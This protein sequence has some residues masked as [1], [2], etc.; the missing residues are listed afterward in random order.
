[1][2]TSSTRSG[3]SSLAPAGRVFAMQSEQEDAVYNVASGTETSLL[4]LWEAIQ[5]VT[6][7]HTTLHVAERLSFGSHYAETLRRWDDA[8]RAASRR[9]HEL[10]FDATFQ[11]MWHFYLEYSRAGFASG[12]LDVEQIILER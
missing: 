1:M 2:S 12:Y 4:G 7:G 8:F 5:R 3:P 6:R 9:V 11:R 10:G